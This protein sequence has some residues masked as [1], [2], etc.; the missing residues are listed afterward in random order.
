[1]ISESEIIE[2]IKKAEES[3]TLDYKED[4]PLETNGDKAEFVKDVISL[5]NSGKAAHI[6]LGVEDKTGR[7]VGFK[8]NHAV[9]QLNQIL[10]DKCDPPIS[11][12][13]MEKNILGYQIGVIEIRCENPPYIVSVPDKFGGPLSTSS[14]KPFYIQRGTVFVRNYNMNE[15]ARRADLDKMY[16]VK[17][18]TL[19]ADLSLVYEVAVKPLDNLTEVDIKFLL[20]NQG[21]VLATDIYV[22]LQ[23]KNIKQIV[24]CTG[25]WT[26]IS[27]I[28]DNVPTIQLIYGAPV[29]PLHS[30]H[31]RGVVV[32]VDRNIK[33]IETRIKIGA[34]NMRTKDGSYNIPIEEKG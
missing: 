5:A 1:M 10:K 11:V 13:Y 12:E 16:Q 29:I 33:Q 2:L 30:M 20:V 19:Q 9:E 17:Y 32:H 8:T 24:K 31:C 15:G 34:A 4:L 18:V 28:N 25:K 3:P 26:D 27:K 23:F 21:D 14:Q 22:W 7:L 6:L